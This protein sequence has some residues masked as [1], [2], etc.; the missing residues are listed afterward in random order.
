VSVSLLTS[1]APA[2]G[3][4]ADAIDAGE[5]PSRSPTAVLLAVG[6]ACGPQGLG[7]LSPSALL[8]LDPAMPIALAI[9][10]VLVGLSVAGLRV[11]TARVLAAAAFEA[12]VAMAAVAGALVLAWRYQLL[13]VMASVAGFCTVCAVAAASSLLLPRGDHSSRGALHLVIEAGVLVPIVLGGV[14]LALFREASVV[15]AILLTAQAIGAVLLLTVAAWLLVGSATSDTERRLFTIAAVMVVGGAA[16][17]LSLSALLGGFVAGAAWHGLNGPARD[18]LRE[19]LRYVRQPFLAMVLVLAGANAHVS[20]SAIALAG[21]YAFARA[22]GKM[23]GAMMAARVDPG[24][25]PAGVGRLLL[26]PG[27]FGVAFAL[28]ALRAVGPSLS[29]ALD[30]V[31][32]GTILADAVAGILRREEPGA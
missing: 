24:G 26:S 5:R 2:V 4:Q 32:L 21:V 1:P 18:A 31:V 3:A 30:V 10:G 22:A 14:A 27:I 20:A 25:M 19:D 13:P 28:N 17:Y 6:V 11:A 16:D 8:A 15:L 9:L 23:I 7:F 29:L 12:A